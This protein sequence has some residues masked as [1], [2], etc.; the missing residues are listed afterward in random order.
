[1]NNEL[2]SV[3][4]P[5][6]NTEQYIT[7]CLQSVQRQTY[8]NFE[9]VIVDDGSTDLSAEKVGEFVRQDSRFRLIS[10]PHAGVSAA[11]S[12]GIANAGGPW[13]Y[14]LDSDDW[15]DADELQRL[16][17]AKCFPSSA[18]KALWRRKT[19]RPFSTP[20]L[21]AMHAIAALSA[22]IPAAVNWYERPWRKRTPAFRKGWPLRRT[23]F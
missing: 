21:Y 18:L 19:S 13:L 3:I 17:A 20:S 14:F 12:N 16:Y 22:E 2:I 5:M 4:I 1:M 11:V 10:Q 8:S 6:Y 23:Q 9:C 7:E 15:I